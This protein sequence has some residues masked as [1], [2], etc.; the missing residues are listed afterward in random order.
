MA[1]QL[2]YP[3]LARVLSLPALRART[4]ADVDRLGG[5]QRAEQTA[6]AQLRRLRPVP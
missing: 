2:A 1:L 4:D 6:P 5:R 3:A